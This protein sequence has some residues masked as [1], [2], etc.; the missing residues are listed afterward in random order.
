MPSKLIE[1]LGEGGKSGRF[2]IARGVGKCLT[3]YTEELWIEE[4]NELRKL[5]KTIQSNK[6]LVRNFSHSAAEVNLDSA[7]RVSLTQMQRALA[8][9]QDEAVIHTFMDDIEIWSKANY[10]SGQNLVPDTFGELREK[11][12]QNKQEK[13]DE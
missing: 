9:I 2:F 13:K 3:I 8:E 11:A 6:L 7:D 4:L 5:D 12:F 1:K 10:E